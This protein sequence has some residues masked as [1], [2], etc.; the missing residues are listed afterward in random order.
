MIN[1][2]F[3]TMDWPLIVEHLRNFCT[4][5]IS[6]EQI[7]R[8]NSVSNAQEA[9]QSF[10]KIFEFVEIVKT[11]Q[12]PHFESLDLFQNW[13]SRLQ[14]KGTL[15]TLELRDVRN[16]CVE[17]L[18]FKELA[19]PYQS[20]YVREVTGK[21]FAPDAPLAA[22]DQVISANGEIRTDASQSLYEYT[23]ERGNLVRKIQSN[24]EKIAKDNQMADV[25]QERF[26]TNR[27]GRWV[28]PVKSGMQRSL[29]GII[30]DTS[31]TKQ[32]VFM[33]PQQ[34][35]PLNN[36]MR[37]LDFLIEEEIEKILRELSDYL[38]QQ[39]YSFS[40]A[41]D[42]LVEI[43]ANMAKAQ[44]THALDAKAPIFSESSI[45]LEDLKHPLLI[46]KNAKEG[47]S[48]IGNT[49][50]LDAKNR[51]LILSGPNAGGKTVLL[52]SMGLASQMARCGLPICAGHGS[53]I[54][55]FKT[56]L[57]IVGD[58]QDVNSSMSTFAAHLHK[59]NSALKLHGSSQLILID[60]ICG[61]TDPEEG[62]ALAKSF[63]IEFVKNGVF[64]VITSHLSQ[65][66]LG[67]A[68]FPE[69]LSGSLEFDPKTGP[70]YRFLSG[71]PGQSLAFQ[72]A[73]RVGVAANVLDQAMQLL[74]PEQQVMQKRL[75]EIEDLKKNI[76][77]L[78]KDLERQKAEATAKIK[79][80]DR[81]KEQFERDREKNLEKLA[82]QY[83]AEIDSLIQAAKGKESFEKFEE[84]KKIKMDLPLIVKTAEKTE[85]DFKTVEE[86]M[87]HF[88]AGKKVFIS[89]LGREGI[90]QGQ[91]NAKGEIPVLSES[92]RLML[93]FSLLK[94]PRTDRGQT[95]EILRTLKSQVS[96]PVQDRVVDLRGRTVEE[97]IAELEV[98]IDQALLNQE[99]RVKVVHGHGSDTL[100]RAIRTHLSRSAYVKKW[101]S[102][103]KESGGDGVTWIELQD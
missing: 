35:V 98:K 103:S 12:R 70:T 29:E 62:S 36:R 41:R 69:V 83:Q 42:L 67:W 93:H 85:E 13:C 102:G 39:V 37:E 40:V 56:L 47:R 34:L 2:E 55:F 24:L 38:S 74:S 5:E 94:A 99:D 89:H 59:L 31:H 33:E 101:Q 21:L 18:T 28:L 91:P 97:A 43:D 14:K 49:V 9:A 17:V 48:V 25:L 65:L 46:L 50:K 71:I 96:P 73:K 22:I 19:K 84:L 63:I 75:D 54:P 100:K 57:V 45:E 81:L 79:E 92:I 44:L 80:A 23:Q 32:T 90:I 61:A 1:E 68:K 72:T 64:G 16:F 52:K 11:G 53:K 6:R 4:S 77:V 51:V 20:T 30:H 26:V 82:K 88:P 78:Q 7:D 87:Q 95:K 86:F 76:G 27:E 66:K 15:K 8:I 10:S 58:D 60:E 3:K